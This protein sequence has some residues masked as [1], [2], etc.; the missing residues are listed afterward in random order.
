MQAATGEKEVLVLR[1]REQWVEILQVVLGQ[2][3]LDLRSELEHWL[4]VLQ[5]LEWLELK[6]RERSLFNPPS[7]QLA[8]LELFPSEPTLGAIRRR[9]T[10]MG[11]GIRVRSRPRM[12][13]A[14]AGNKGFYENVQ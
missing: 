2:R 9:R 3:A 12:S 4:E 1:V 14:R 10:N 11:S 6:E 13:R 7:A 8:V 5:M